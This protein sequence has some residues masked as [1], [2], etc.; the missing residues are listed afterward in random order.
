M[1]ELLPDD[2]VHSS[3]NQD[4]LN[5]LWWGIRSQSGA[6]K[7][8]LEQGIPL[9]GPA[10]EPLPGR[11]TTAQTELGALPQNFAVL[12]GAIAGLAEQVSQLAKAQGVVIDYDE[13]ARKTADE[14]ASRMAG[15][16]A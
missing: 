6:G 11:H 14:I 15:G 13:I 4:K 3:T 1:P 5:D 7:A 12:K 8:I 2:N 16:H 9:L 10:W